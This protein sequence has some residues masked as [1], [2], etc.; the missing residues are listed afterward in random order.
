M[1]TEVRKFEELTPAEL[2]EL[3]RI[4]SAVFVVEQNCAYQDIDGVDCESVHVFCREDD[5][6]VAACLR[7]FRVR[8]RE[9]TVQIGR[10]LV[11]KGRRGTGLGGRLLREGIRV[12]EDC[13]HAKRIV[14]EAQTYAVGFYAREGFRVCSEEFLEDGIPHVRMEREACVSIDR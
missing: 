2:Y 4:R 7:L 9:D 1:K 5:G 3:L 12:A 13:L 11:A 8:G 14:L 10:V 6:S